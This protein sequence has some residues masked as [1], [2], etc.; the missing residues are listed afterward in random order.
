MAP[1]LVLS[2]LRAVVFIAVTQAAVR[3]LP[4]GQLPHQPCGHA[5]AVTGNE[6]LGFL[7]RQVLTSRNLSGPLFT[8]FLFGGLDSQIEHHLFPSMPR[9]NLRRARAVVRPFCAE[10]AIAY[11]EQTPWHAY[12]DV[13]HHLRSVGSSRAAVVE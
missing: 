3:L 1:F 8:C 5:D 6:D 2:P 7:R 13:L 11:T 9:A 12:R 4:R 10:R